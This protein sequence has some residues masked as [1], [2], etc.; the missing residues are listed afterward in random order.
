MPSSQ[1]EGILVSTPRVTAKDNVK[2][3]SKCDLWYLHAAEVVTFWFSGGHGSQR[4]IKHTGHTSAVV[5]Y[6]PN[7]WMKRNDY[8]EAIGVM[9]NLQ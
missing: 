2:S 7:E 8:N 1:I 9:P 4:M 3:L 5:V 6:Q